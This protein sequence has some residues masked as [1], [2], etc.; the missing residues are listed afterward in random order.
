MPV[1]YAITVTGM[2]GDE[3]LEPPIPSPR[4]DRSGEFVQG[5]LA[6][7]GFDMRVRPSGTRVYVLFSRW[8]GE[9]KPARITIGRLDGISF[10]DARQR[11]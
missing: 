7:P 2:A 10:V 1:G 4:P 5:D 8:P 3:G 6:A 9:T 11:A